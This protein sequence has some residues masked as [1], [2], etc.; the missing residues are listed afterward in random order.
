MAFCVQ[1]NILEQARKAKYFSISLDYAPDLNHRE[2]MS[3]T[4]RFTDVCES[5]LIV[6]EHFITF[7]E[8]EETT[9]HSLFVVIKNCLRIQN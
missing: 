4:L 2:Q 3:F 5:D 6:Q 8:T 7:Q 9:G 1:D